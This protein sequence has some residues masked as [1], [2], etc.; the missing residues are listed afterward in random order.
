MVLEYS[1][2]W[3]LSVVGRVSEISVL[4]GTLFCLP[5]SGN[6]TEKAGP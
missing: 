3:S 1:R 6:G 2:K 5:S 4:L